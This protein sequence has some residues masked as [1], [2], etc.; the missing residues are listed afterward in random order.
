[1]IVKRHFTPVSMWPYVRL[2]LGIA[3]A[4]STAAWL[5]AGRA[6]WTQW[7]LPAA[8]AT[9]LGT[10]L[11]ILLAVRANTSYQRWW[12]AS[13][14]WAQITGLSRTVVR[15]AVS[16]SNSKPDADPALVQAFQRDIAHRQI[17]YATALRA[18]LRGH[19]RTD[20]TPHLAR[21]DP[22]EREALL[23]SDNTAIMLLAG[24]SAR[25][26]AAYREGLLTGLDNFQMETALAA[27]S[28][29]Q[30]LAERISMQPVPRTYDVFSRYLVHLYS[31]VFP[32]AII[33]TLP[34]HRWLV[35]PAAL[36]ISFAFRIVER[37]GSIVEAPFA[38]TTQD[39]PLTAIGVLLE[40]DLLELTGATGRPA[41]PAPANG[42]LW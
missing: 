11:S 37:I 17:A 19:A 22:A 1:M 40:R 28:T 32:F 20:L 27:L 41:A 30:A 31:V 33:E 42:Y 3:A 23:A 13:G 6:N 21:L 36:I 34:A 7:T 29:Q 18:Q 26:F 12:E 8:V 2:E 16:V 15:V 14:I 38:N 10:A 9:V 35:I 24:Q 39:V 4:S 25:I 5:L